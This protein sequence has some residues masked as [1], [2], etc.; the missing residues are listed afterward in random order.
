MYG[1]SRFGSVADQAR[2]FIYAVIDRL[3]GLDV[4]G[5]PAHRSQ[6]YARPPDLSS[7]YRAT[8]LKCMHGISDFMQLQHEFERVSAGKD[9]LFS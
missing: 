3:G 7:T 2:G 1:T 6:R 9:K 8:Q 5:R 4:E